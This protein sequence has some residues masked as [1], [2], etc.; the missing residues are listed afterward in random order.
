MKHIHDT[1]SFSSLASEAD[2]YL[3]KPA[4]LISEAKSLRMLCEATEA[5]TV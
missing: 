4:F 3:L 2:S 5:F 1:T